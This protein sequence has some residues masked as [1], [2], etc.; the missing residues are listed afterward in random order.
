M[1]HPAFLQRPK[2]KTSRSIWCAR[3]LVE[4]GSVRPID[5]QILDFR[6]PGRIRRDTE[7]GFAHRY[8]QVCRYGIDREP[9]GCGHGRDRP[10]TASSRGVGRC[11]WHKI[12][13]MGPE[14]VLMLGVWWGAA[15]V[16]TML[17]MAI[18]R[19][20]ERFQERRQLS[21]TAHAVVGGPLE[22]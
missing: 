11:T 1:V 20:L 4:L 8:P 2:S 19:G 22:R 16:V 9:A 13:L 15:V 7:I 21:R 10:V 3:R 14:Y 6:S 5:A 17:A 18:R 12:E